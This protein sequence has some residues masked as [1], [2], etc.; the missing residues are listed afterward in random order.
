MELRYVLRHARIR[1]PSASRNM[2]AILLLAVLLLVV[3]C[4]C[5]RQER[6]NQ[7][8]ALFSIPFWDMTV[9]ELTEKL[10]QEGWVSFQEENNK[11]VYQGVFLGHPA[12][13]FCNYNEETGKV[14]ALRIENSA[15]L[16]S[17]REAFHS[18]RS[19][20]DADTPLRWSFLLNAEETNVSYDR[21][22]AHW[23]F[24]ARDSVISAGGI[25]QENTGMTFTAST[26]ESF[27]DTIRENYKAQ[28]HNAVHSIA[29]PFG[30]RYYR[31]PNGVWVQLEAT[32]ALRLT[33]PFQLGT[34]SGYMI[35]TCILLSPDY[36]DESG[37]QPQKDDFSGN[38]GDHPTAVS[39]S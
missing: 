37:Y 19:S 12:G 10:E 29:I 26:E 35:G 15:Y 4:G 32:A 5:T 36:Q 23:L 3:I 31:L 24:V 8:E 21:W 28:E 30:V 18:M 14:N 17:Y 7:F 1:L 38:D 16:E 6:N 39:F 11:M 13:L 9:Q 34:A 27:A 22:V 33:E 25:F 20:H 2:S